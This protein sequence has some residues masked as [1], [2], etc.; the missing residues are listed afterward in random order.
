[1]GQTRGDL[2]HRK[3]ASKVDGKR[4]LKL[5]EQ[6]KSWEEIASDFGFL[7]TL[8]VRRAAR[9]VSNGNSESAASR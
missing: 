7:D 8:T 3:R 1:M 9:E 6:G 2:V 5:R 4:V